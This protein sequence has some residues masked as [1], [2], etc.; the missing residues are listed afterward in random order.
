VPRTSIYFHRKVH[1][2][3]RAIAFEERKSV[4]GVIHDALDDFLR[5]RSFPTTEEL[6]RR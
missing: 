1:D 2:Q 5:K 6:K 3:I 4:A